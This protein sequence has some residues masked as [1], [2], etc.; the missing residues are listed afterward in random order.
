MKKIAPLNSEQLR[1]TIVAF[2]KTDNWNE[3]RRI[4]EQ[5]SELLTTEADALLQRLTRIQKDD[6]ARQT[7]EFYRLILQHCRQFGIEATFADVL[8]PDEMVNELIVPHQFL[9]HFFTLV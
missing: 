9:E 3:R 4:V 5:H 7:I 8:A 2:I 1:D 6:S